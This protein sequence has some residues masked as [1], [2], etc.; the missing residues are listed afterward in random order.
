MDTKKTKP[1]FSETF[2]TRP[3]LFYAFFTLVC[4]IYLSALLLDPSM[5]ASLTH[6]ASRSSLFLFMGLMLLVLWALYTYGSG[7][8]VVEYFH[9]RIGVTYRKQQRTIP[10]K[11]IS[12]IWMG[13]YWSWRRNRLFGGPFFHQ[14]FQHFGEAYPG[15]APGQTDGWRDREKP[16]EVLLW[17]LDIAQFGRRST[18]ERFLFLLPRS[19]AKPLMLR[20]QDGKKVLEYLRLHASQ[21]TFSPLIED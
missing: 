12:K 2:T 4:V 10:L 5:R 3:T 14:G 6:P 20:T 18:N 16:V 11:N 7:K 19:D 9:D 13:R 17:N 1:I 8:I 21:A 15:S